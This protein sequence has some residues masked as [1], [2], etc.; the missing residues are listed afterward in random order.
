MLS[1]KELQALCDAIT[2][3]DEKYYKGVLF[4]D[5]A[6]RKTTTALRCSQSRAILIH[7]DR[8]WNVIR[9]HPNEFP[10][11]KVIPIRY[12][13]LSQ[14]RGIVEA[15]LSQQ[16][17][18]TS[19]DLIV[20]DTI[21]QVQENY[22][23]FLG[24]NFTIFGR[25]KAIPKSGTGEKEIALTGLPDYHLT[26]NKMRPVI[27]LL[28]RAPIDVIFTAHVREP[29]MNDI[30]NGKIA[31]RPNVTEAVFNLLA[32]D[33]TFIGY[34]EAKK[35]NYTTTFKPS[36]TIVAKSQITELTDK[37]IQSSELPQY[38]LNWKNS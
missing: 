16:D 11:E 34:M 15:V 1:Q 23:D 24:D 12:E 38:L 36:P 13:A 19:V 7:A 6:K 4:G 37:T 2:D 21:S 18:F 33:A 26:R 20:V 8:G 31:K 30:K 5:Y 17:P 32:R 27:E 25:E 29:N 28:V 3:Y 35:D 14:I 9:N 10:R 22:I